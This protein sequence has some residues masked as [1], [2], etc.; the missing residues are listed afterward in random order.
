M[1]GILI[2]AF[3]FSKMVSYF[4]VD[5]LMGYWFLRLLIDGS[6]L[7]SHFLVAALELLRDEGEKIVGTPPPENTCHTSHGDT[8]HALSSGSP[9]SGYT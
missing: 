8:W 9:P 6:P 5:S 4:V 7:E 3:C 1:L 2:T